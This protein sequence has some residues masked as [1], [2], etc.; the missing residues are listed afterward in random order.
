MLCWF[1]LI[2]EEQL[3]IQNASNSLVTE[4]LLHYFW[5]HWGCPFK[6]FKKSNGLQWK[7][8]PAGRKNTAQEIILQIQE[9]LKFDSTI[10]TCLGSE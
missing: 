10:L 6:A 4:M 7:Q 8:E 3:K 1:N 5:K 9:K 2:L